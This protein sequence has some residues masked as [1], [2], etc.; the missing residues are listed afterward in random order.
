MIVLLTGAVLCVPDVRRLTRRTGPEPAAIGAA[1]RA[2]GAT[3][4]HTAEAE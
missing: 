2:A 4:P 1:S 3:E